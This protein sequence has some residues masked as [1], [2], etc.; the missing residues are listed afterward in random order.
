MRVHIQ[1]PPPGDPFA[2]TLDQWAEAATR[3]GSIG[4][5]HDVSI[6]ATEAEFARAM[7]EAEALITDVDTLRRL[8]PRGATRLRLVSVTSAGLDT[9]A[10][11]DWLPDGAVLLNNRGAHAVKAGE[12]AIMAVLMLAS[13]M[14]AMVTAQRA[15]RWEKRWG[16]ALGG[17]RITIVGLGTLGGAAAM[18]AARFGMRVTG[19]RTEGGAHPHCERVIATADLDAMLPTT[20]CLLLASPL[21]EATRGL[22]DRRRLLLLPRGA[23][24]VNIGRGGLLDQDALCDL[25]EE[26]HLSGAVLDVFTPE[27]V[28]P[29]H[30]LWRTPNLVMSPHTS[31]DDPRTYNPLSL[32]IFFDNLR[33]LRDGRPLPNRFDTARGY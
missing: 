18:Q 14:P 31:A 24:L 12:F 20:E 28:P 4:A 29:G 1:N 8:P 13:G 15:E 3:A 27:P 2:F 22:I 6:S 33:A 17:Q 23:G 26:G 30:R 32:D 11:Y 9:L 25:L 21:T 10:P 7:T 16:H 5:D 19:V